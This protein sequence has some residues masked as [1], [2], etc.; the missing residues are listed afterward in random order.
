MFGDD[1][2]VCLEERTERE[3]LNILLL[4]GASDNLIEETDICRL[5]C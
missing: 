3:A 4:L 5:H 2:V 1:F